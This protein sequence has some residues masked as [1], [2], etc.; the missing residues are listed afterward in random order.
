MRLIQIATI[1]LFMLSGYT[2]SPKEKFS[3]GYSA[4]WISAETNKNCTATVWFVYE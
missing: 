1:F 4:H 3:K 2:L